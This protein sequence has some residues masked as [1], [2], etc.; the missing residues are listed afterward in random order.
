MLGRT[1]RDRRHSVGQLTAIF[2][3]RDSDSRIVQAQLF[4]YRSLLTFKLMKE[5]PLSYRDSLRMLRLLIPNM[6]ILG[7]HHS[8]RPS[9]RKFCVLH[10]GK[11]G[12]P[13]RLEISYELTAEELRSNRADERAMIRFFRRL[14]CL[15]LKF[16][17]PGEGASLHYA[18]TFPIRPDGGSLTCDH[19][20]R[21]RD[22]RNVYLADGS[23]FP[24]IPPKGL[25]FNLMANADRVGTLLA[26]QL[27]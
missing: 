1:P 15:P 2:R 22:T 18:G 20:G 19:R 17:R 16:V 9:P 5:L 11:E 21:L 6:A 4:S 24:W 14:G 25:T 27:R 26:E 3:P 10:R 12:S 8:D 7:I 13:D 23:V